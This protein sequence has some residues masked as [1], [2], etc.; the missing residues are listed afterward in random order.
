MTPLVPPFGSA[1]VTDLGALFSM[2]ASFA[3]SGCLP[4]AKRLKDATLART[5]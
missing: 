1:S 5:R 4:V 2:A 3:A